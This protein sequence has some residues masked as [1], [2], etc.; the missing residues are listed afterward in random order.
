MPNNIFTLLFLFRCFLSV[1]PDRHSLFAPSPLSRR[2]L[3]LFFLLTLDIEYADLLRSPIFRR[4][5]NTPMECMYATCNP[6]SNL[7]PILILTTTLPRSILTTLNA[8]LCDLLCP[9]QSFLLVTFQFILKYSFI[10]L[11]FFTPTPFILFYSFFIP[12]FSSCLVFPLSIFLLLTPVLKPLLSHLHSILL[13]KIWLLL[14]YHMLT[15]MLKRSSFL[16]SLLWTPSILPTILICSLSPP[17]FMMSVTT[18]TL[19]PFPNI[20]FFIFY[21]HNLVTIE[22]HSHSLSLTI[23]P[24]LNNFPLL[25]YLMTPPCNP[26]L[27][28]L[29]MLI[30]SNLLV[31]KAYLGLLFT[32]AINLR[33]TLSP[34]L[35][36]SSNIDKS[37][38]IKITLLLRRSLAPLPFLCTNL[39]CSHFFLGKKNNLLSLFPI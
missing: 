7:H 23:F 24:F 13:N 16:P 39:L 33:S 14:I 17:F 30:G 18:S 20:H 38:Y 31:L 37:N 29:E 34:K 21:N 3:Y 35:S 12:P 26:M 22:Q 27:L 36:T 15:N 1:S 6:T 11:N 2:I 19:T 32:I 4:N 10:N 8:F 28:L 25:L 5:M 9:I